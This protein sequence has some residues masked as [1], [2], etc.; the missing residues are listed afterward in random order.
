MFLTTVV[1]RL[2]VTRRVVTYAAIALGLVPRTGP[3]HT[4]PLIAWCAHV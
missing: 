4:C 1:S 2:F 3:S